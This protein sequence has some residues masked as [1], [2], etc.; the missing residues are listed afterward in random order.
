[1]IPPPQAECLLKK[2][3][4]FGRFC[5]IVE[6]SLDSTILAILVMIRSQKDGF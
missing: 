4:F 5:E 6:S 1:M 2:L 3:D